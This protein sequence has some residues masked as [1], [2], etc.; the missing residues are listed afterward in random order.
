MKIGVVTFFDNGNYGSELQAIATKEF[1]ANRGHDVTFL[2]IQS[3][4]KVVR[5]IKRMRSRILVWYNCKTDKVYSKYYNDRRKNA[6][7]Q[8]IISFELKSH[9]HGS[10]AQFI[11][12]QSISP[13][14]MRHNSPFDCYICGSDQIWSALRI[15]VWV[16]NFLEGVSP[17]RKIA[18]APSLGVNDVPEYYI[19]SIAPLVRDFKFLSVREDMAA[20]ILEKRIGVK[21]H[22]VVDPTILVGRKTWD[23]LLEKEKLPRLSN[24]YIFCY[25]LGEINNNL[26][27]FLNNFAKGR[28]IIILPYEHHAEN[29][30]NGKYVLANQF[31]FLNYI[32]YADYVFTDS[33]H[34]TVFSLLY[35]REFAVFQRSHVGVA[36]QSTRV[37]SLLSTYGLMNRLVNFPED[38]NL[39]PKIDYDQIN[40]K[41]QSEREKSINFL[42]GALNEIVKYI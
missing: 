16:E 14:K 42:D 41:L 19:R 25:F 29:L 22:V 15:P 5:F 40:V 30:I 33:F 8:P 27:N 4:N 31:E 39:L 17:M 28:E 36:K 26:I 1:C 7:V 10:V 38:V 35:N 9:I 34:G 11:K 20:N 24:S 12:S 37:E 18:Y 32:R 13:W 21:P 23:K 6:I 2:R 3:N